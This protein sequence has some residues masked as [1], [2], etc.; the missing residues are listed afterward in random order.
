MRYLQGQKDKGQG[1]KVPWNP[2]KKSSTDKLLFTTGM[3]KVWT[4]RM[5]I[6]RLPLH[7][8]NPS[9]STL[10]PMPHSIDVPRQMG[11]ATLYKLVMR[12]TG[13]H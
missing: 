12:P 3:Y 11:G 5:W 1:Y 4:C 8:H 13:V 7:E 10:H 9:A 2:T 6:A